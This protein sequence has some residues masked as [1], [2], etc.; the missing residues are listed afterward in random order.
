MPRDVGSD[1]KARDQGRDYSVCHMFICV[2]A[3]L[4]GGFPCTSQD[5]SPPLEVFCI[6]LFPFIPPLVA[7]A[8]LSMTLSR[9]FSTLVFICWRP[10]IISNL[11]TSSSNLLDNS[12]LFLTSPQYAVQPLVLP[13]SKCQIKHMIPLKK[14]LQDNNCY[15]IDVGLFIFNLSTF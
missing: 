9:L 3:F 4:V 7:A 11:C 2:F 13:L 15:S 10:S 12:D 14:V 1:V 5:T 8:W 6:D